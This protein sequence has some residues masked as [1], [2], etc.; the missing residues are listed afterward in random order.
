VAD[1]DQFVED[2]IRFKTAPEGTEWRDFTD[3]LPLWRAQNALGLPLRPSL[4]SV[5]GS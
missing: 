4:E 3:L 2:S 1:V 5:A